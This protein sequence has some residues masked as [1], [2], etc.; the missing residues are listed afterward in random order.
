MVLTLTG[1]Q[2]GVGLS[3]GGSGW[4]SVW[5]WLCVLLEGCPLGEAGYMGEGSRAR[6]EDSAFYTR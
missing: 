3:G 4:L 2:C 5:V 6:G 1:L